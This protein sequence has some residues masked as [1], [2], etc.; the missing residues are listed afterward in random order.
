MNFIP[1]SEASEIHT[2][3]DSAEPTG[4]GKHS[5]CVGNFGSEEKSVGLTLGC[6]VDGPDASTAEENGL[7]DTDERVRIVI[8]LV[9]T[10]IQDRNVHLVEQTYML[11]NQV[12][13][14][15]KLEAR[16]SN[17]QKVQKLKIVWSMLKKLGK[18]RRL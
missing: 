9:V 4:L 10:V 5:G 2:T 13:I 18:Q 6:S 17:M 14:Q 7:S 12:R 1:V 8:V 3:M 15:V 16:I 11:V